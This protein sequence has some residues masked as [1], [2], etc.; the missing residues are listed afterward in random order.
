[1]C[2]IRHIQTRPQDSTRPFHPGSAET[3]AMV[4]VEGARIWLAKL[5]LISSVRRA[6]HFLLFRTSNTDSST[7]NTTAS[8]PNTMP[9]LIAIT[10]AYVVATQTWYTV[11]TRL[12]SA[13]EQCSRQ[14][15]ALSM[16]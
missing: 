5:R 8:T 3:H 15:P 16:T 1:M 6:C 7:I 14:F 13:P 9:Q 2:S 4:L 11:P 10:S 12:I